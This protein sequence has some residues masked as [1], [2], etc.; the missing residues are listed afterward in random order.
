MEL[1]LKTKIQPNQ[2]FDNPYLLSKLFSCFKFI[3]V[4]FFFLTMSVLHLSS[5]ENC[6]ALIP[7]TNGQIDAPSS[8]HGS[9]ATISCS[10]GYE[11][12]A[13]VSTLLCT[14]GTYNGTVPDCLGEQ[15]IPY[16]EHKINKTKT[17]QTN[18]TIQ[19]PFLY[20]FIVRVL[21]SHK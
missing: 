17:K 5:T 3:N 18:N 14:D 19:K 12:S 1:T 9:L 20:N 4:I 8:D 6:P 2:I 10:D 16:Y 15:N 13:P 21:H 11:L 7:P